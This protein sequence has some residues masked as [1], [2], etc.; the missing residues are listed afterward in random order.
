MV[1]YWIGYERSYVDFP[2]GPCRLLQTGENKFFIPGKDA[3]RFFQAL[4]RELG[5]GQPE[6]VAGSGSQALL[7]QGRRMRGSED[8]EIRSLIADYR[9]RTAYAD[10]H[11][12]PEDNA[13]IGV[14]QARCEGDYH[15][16]IQLLAG[17]KDGPRRHRQLYA[18]SL[19]NAFEFYRDAN[20]RMID[21]AV[22]EFGHLASTSRERAV[23][24]TR[25]S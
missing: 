25:S 23:S 4:M 22:T 10:K 1:V 15:V 24:M 2:T 8:K 20:G 9:E 21:E 13:R 12:A 3:D 14:L 7:D 18:L 6:W 11:R 5:E 19:Q 17:S 16:A